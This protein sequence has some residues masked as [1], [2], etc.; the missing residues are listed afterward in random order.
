MIY[1]LV[2]ENL[3]LLAIDSENVFGG[4]PSIKLIK[5]QTLLYALFACEMLWFS[6]YM[7]KSIQC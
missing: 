5:L 4:K 1:Y 6:G 7:S 3:L 2:F